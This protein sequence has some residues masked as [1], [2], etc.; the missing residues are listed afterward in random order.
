MIRALAFATLS[1]V[2]ASQ[3][4]AQGSSLETME[5]AVSLG[6]ILGSEQFCGLS[7]DQAAIQ[8]FI[9]EK[10]PADD[11]GF[12]SDLSMMTSG[13]TFQQSGMSES[14]K[15]AHCAAVARTARHY[16]FIK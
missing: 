3:A 6:S 13:A 4:I 14:S 11:M 15:T 10:I 1:L 5:L 8:A 2:G 7:F 9:D 16:G 12:A